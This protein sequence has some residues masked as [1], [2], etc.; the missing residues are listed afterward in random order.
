MS[1]ASLLGAMALARPRVSVVFATHNR[2]DRLAELLD[3]LRRQSVDSVDFEVVVVDDGSRDRT[4]SVL[5]EAVRADDLRLRRLRLEPAAGPAAARNAG[6]RSAA[7]PLVA[8]T[9]D[10][11]VASPRWLEAGL[12]AAEQAPGAIVQGRTDP[13]PDEADALGPFSRTLHVHGKGPYYQTCNVFYP[14]DLLE[15]V[16]GFDE[17]TF[18]VPGGED[19]DLAWRA[20]EQGAQTLFAEEAQ[21]YHAVSRLGAV[22]KL[23]V[24]WRWS[25]TVRIYARHPELRRTALVH[26]LFWKRT[27]LLL[28]QLMVAML[29]PNHAALRGWLAYPYLRHLPGRGRVEGGG[30]AL[31]PYY[32]LHDLVELAA[33]IRGSVRYRSLVL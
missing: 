1:A 33:M 16:G 11:C 14:R 10:D 12:A 20:M 13:R 2:A 15:R 24:A 6:W 29:L 4:P 9:D 32:L 7:A 23:R 22:G 8:F 30:L 27:H 28:V 5:D 21:V 26:G 25:E 17:Q 19:A 3:S 31:A 18:T